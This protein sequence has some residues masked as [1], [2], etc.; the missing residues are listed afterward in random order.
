MPD[1]DA[2]DAL[3][4]RLVAGAQIPNRAQRDDLRRELATHFEAAG[5]SAQALDDALTR[6]G[7]EPLVID[8]LRRVYRFDYFVLYLAKVGASIAV[9]VAAAVLIELLVNL[10][11][12]FQAG[13]RL[14]PNFSRGAGLAVAVVVGLVML[15]EGN[16]PPFTRSRAAVAIG[17][18]GVVYLSVRLAFAAGMAPFVTA[19]ML[20]VLGHLC[21]RL[22]TQPR[23][24]LLVFAAFAAALY[25]NHLGLRVAFGPARALMASAVLVSVWASTLGILTRV[26]RTFVEWFEPA[27][28]GGA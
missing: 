9:S 22:S 28:S 4:D 26:D 11:V 8:S 7:P 12:E 23:R 15:Y 14:A 10:R 1:R 20:V 6:F 13:L 19:T 24:L 25:L 18:Y 16:R 17:A 21:S 5:A 3:I 2:V 27:R